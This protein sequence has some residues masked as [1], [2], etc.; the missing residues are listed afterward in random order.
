M[1]TSAAAA[2]VVELHEQ[3]T[4]LAMNSGQIGAWPRPEGS[5]HDLDRLCQVVP[6]T[7]ERL[8]Q[9]TPQPSSLRRVAR[10]AADRE[11]ETRARATRATRCRI[12]VLATSLLAHA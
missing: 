2:T 8:P 10:F 3:R 4:Q 5:D 1:L 11:A 6:K 9:Q 7:S 12:W